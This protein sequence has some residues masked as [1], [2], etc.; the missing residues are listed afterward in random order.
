MGQSGYLLAEMG[1][2]LLVDLVI[3]TESASQEMYWQKS[4]WSH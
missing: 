1:V 2:N 4:G 3:V